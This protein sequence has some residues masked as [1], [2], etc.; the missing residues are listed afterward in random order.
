MTLEAL[1][2]EIASLDRRIID[3]IAERQRL[4][5]R[6][7]EFKHHEGLPV[8]DPHQR[9]AVLSRAF[10]YAAEK[11][12]DPA[13]TRGIFALLIQMSEERQHEFLGEGN[14]P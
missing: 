11:N 13:E 2:D 8:T 1:R 5:A 10:D 3:L 12:I 6:M 14:L 7:A 9:E 4:A